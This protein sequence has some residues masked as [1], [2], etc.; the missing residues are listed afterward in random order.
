MTNIVSKTFNT[1]KAANAFMADMAAKYP[2]RNY[3]IRY[4]PGGG[5][6]LVVVCTNP[7]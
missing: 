2:N 6:K 4:A 1:N 3:A 5:G 7:G